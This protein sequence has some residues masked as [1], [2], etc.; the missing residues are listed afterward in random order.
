[1]KRR[2]NRAVLAGALVIAMATAVAGLRAQESAQPLRLTAG[3]VTGI[4]FALSSA[5][6]RLLEPDLAVRVRTCEVQSSQGSVSNLRLVRAGAADIGMAQADMVG[7]AFR[8]EGVFA[9]G[10]PNPNLRVLFSTVFEKLTVILAPGSAIND[11]KELL[12]RR[13]DFGPPGSGSR[14]SALRYLE[15]RDLGLEDFTVVW[16]GT[17]SLSAQQLCRGGADAFIFISAHPNSVVQEAIANCAATVFLGAGENLER[18][19][20]QY[21][22]YSRVAIEADF[23]PEITANVDTFGVPAIV[24]ADARLDED[25]AYRLTKTVFEQLD[26]LRVLHISFRD[27]TID[28]LL[29]PC[30]GAPYHAGALRYFAEVGITP[31]ACD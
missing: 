20:R 17:S 14:A 25:E 21:P 27:L 11:F 6:C 12:G 24:I 28:D 9:Q 22:E 16:T 31:P 7:L 5:F 10:G 1:M 29:R 8:G 2:T 19:T 13:V 18:F 30:A 26:A 23:Y 3:G 15:S 4:Y